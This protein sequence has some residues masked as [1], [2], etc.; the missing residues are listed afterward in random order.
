VL[1]VTVT[2][3]VVVIILF[4]ISSSIAD[5]VL[6]QLGLRFGLVL[7]VVTEIVMA[8]GLGVILGK[9]IARLSPIPVNGALKGILLL[10]CNYLVFP[11]SSFLHHLSRDSW[12]VEIFLE[13]LLVCM[14]AGFVVTNF[15]S[16]RTE[17]QRLVD[18]VGP[19]V[20]II[21]FTL[22]GASLDLNTLVQTW[23]IALLLFAARLLGIFIG[24]LAG[25]TAAGD[26]WRLNRVTWM[27][28]VTQAGIGLGLAR[29]VAVEFPGW[30][31]SFATMMIAVIILNQLVGP[32]LFKWVL[33]LAGE[34][35]VHAGHRDLRGVPLA[36]IFGWEGQSIALARQLNDHGWVVKVVTLKTDPIEEFP[37]REIEILPVLDLSPASLEEVGAQEAQAFV[38]LM[39]D[40]ENLEICRAAYEK[41]GIP[42]VIVR[43][44]ER[45]F[46]EDYRAL[47]ATILDPGLAMVSLLDHFVRSP[48]A[49]ALLLGMDSE[50][51]VVDLIVWN[52]DL[53]GIALRDLTLPVDTLVLSVSRNDASLI[54]HGYTRLELGDRVTIVGSESSLEKVRLRFSP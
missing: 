42:T 16:S 2:M 28:F 44:H 26:P 41:F 51:D 35:H 29:E 23:H 27:A 24:S 43:S 30:G 33:H 7:L 17:F 15:S 25:G 39:E 45:S 4:T 38:S 48:S 5:A 1:G 12:P 10:A 18:L 54:S 52:P 21:F 36:V 9:I 20:Y 32:P 22:T 6:G 14:V 11:F 31:D 13:P 40:K 46:W 50:Q 37:E 8:A 19:T 47:G 49:T 53:H 34:S 3:D